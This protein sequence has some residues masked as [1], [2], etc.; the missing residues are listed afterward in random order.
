MACSQD[1]ALAIDDFAA[2]RLDAAAS[3]ALLDHL[4]GCAECSASFDLVADLMRSGVPRSS[5]RFIGA[6]LASAALLLLALTLWWPMSR[7]GRFQALASADPLVQM[8]LVLR[9][10][11]SNKDAFQGA[12]E[13]YARSDFQAARDALSRFIAGA[14]DHAPAHLYLGI[15]LLQLGEAEAATAP[16]QR[17]AELGE[18]LLAE[19]ALWYLGNACLMLGQGE[20]ALAVFRELKNRE[21]DY[22]LNA[23]AMVEGIREN[24][25]E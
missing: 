22:E 16:L 9:S 3:E 4:E 20:E 10:G 25:E 13:P 7:Q 24:L 12:M 11:A 1:H 14:P 6:L 17:A 5:L 2:G 8:N 21:G 18:N 19:R 15:A 23:R